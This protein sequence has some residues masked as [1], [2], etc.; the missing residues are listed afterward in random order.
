MNALCPCCCSKTV[1]TCCKQGLAA[2]PLSSYL[3]LTHAGE[4]GPELQPASSQSVP[5]VK[6]EA[7]L[8]SLRR[9]Q[10]FTY[11]DSRLE[12]PVPPDSGWAQ[13]GRPPGEAA[14]Q[15]E[16]STR[17]GPAK[18]QKAAQKAEPEASVARTR[19]NVTVVKPSVSVQSKLLPEGGAPHASS[20][21][22]RK[23]P[24]GVKGN[25]IQSDSKH[26]LVEKYKAESAAR[27]QA[28]DQ[29][30]GSA[31]RTGGSVKAPL[32]SHQAP[33]SVKP[34]A[35]A[36]SGKQASLQGKL[37]TATKLSAKAADRA[38]TPMRASKAQ[39]TAQG[40]APGASRAKQ[41]HSS[42]SDSE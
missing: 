18:V 37:K 10:S 6:P 23:A 20:Q 28:S 33:S 39:P 32:P 36:S 31:S 17:A 29:Q 38:A 12:P 14:P 13:L 19:S 4:D 5:G 1:C 3:L 21:S 34:V 16:P 8:T 7:S 9:R 22:V 11:A 15:Q 42:E 40:K 26:S 27:K 25:A 24:V 41:P 30:A 35:A 2:Q